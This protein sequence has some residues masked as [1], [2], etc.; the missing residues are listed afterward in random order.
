M[1]MRN[2]TA[3]SILVVEDELLVLILTESMLTEAG[4]ETLTASDVPEAVTLLRSNADIDVL[5]TDI[6][7]RSAVDGG[8]TLRKRRCGCAPP[9]TSSMPAL[10]P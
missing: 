6:S 4:Y 3:P 2:P 10:D 8:L 7:L 1:S 9:S 5:F